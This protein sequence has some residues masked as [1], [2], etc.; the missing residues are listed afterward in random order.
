MSEEVLSRSG[1]Y[2]EVPPQLKVKE[3]FIQ[4]R[5]YIVCVNGEEAK[6]DVMAREVMVSSLKQKLEK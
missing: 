2:Q 5:R 4:D 6:K 3:V 1:R